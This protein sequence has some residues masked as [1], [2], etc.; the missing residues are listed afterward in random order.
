MGFCLLQVDSLVD[1]KPGRLD[2]TP[3]LEHIDRALIVHDCTK[4]IRSCC[5]DR[6]RKSVDKKPVIKRYKWIQ[7]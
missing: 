1:H 5:W 6:V 2:E 7:I 4:E 3:N